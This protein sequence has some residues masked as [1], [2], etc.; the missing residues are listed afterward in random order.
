M[1]L[2]LFIGIF[3]FLEESKTV[4]VLGGLLVTLATL[5]IMLGLAL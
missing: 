1:L 2:S 5:G 4:R 3:S